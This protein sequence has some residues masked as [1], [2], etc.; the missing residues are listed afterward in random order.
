MKS[1]LFYEREE[2]AYGGSKC[3]HDGWLRTVVMIP[4]TEEKQ[5]VRES[6][7]R[8]GITVEKKATLDYD[9]ETMT[10]MMEEHNAYL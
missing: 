4:D 1:A 10:P 9:R 3:V 6:R 8:R 2:D 5:Q 7:W